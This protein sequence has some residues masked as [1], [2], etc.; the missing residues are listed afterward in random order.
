MPLTSLPPPSLATHRIG[1]YGLVMG[2]EWPVIGRGDELA[3]IIAAVRRG[4][5]CLVVGE[6]GVGKTIVLRELRRRL[7]AQGRSAHLVLVTAVAQFPLQRVGTARADEHAVLVI[8]DAHLLDAASA[9]QVW[10]LAATGTTVV[11]A[12]RAGAPVPDNIERLWRADRCTRL[13]LGPFDRADVQALLE[14]VLGDDVEDRVTRLLLRRTGGNALL[15]RELVRSAVEAGALVRRHGVWSLAGELPLGSGV[16]ELIRGGLAGLNEAELRVARLLAVGEPVPLAVAD[17]LIGRP[18]LEALEERRVVALQEAV[19][20]LVVTLGHPL[21]GE[22]LRADIPALQLRRLHL[23]LARVIE[24]V[25]PV[26]P[27]DVVRAALWRVEAG[28][29]GDAASLLTAAGLARAFSAPSAERL[30]EAAMEA[31]ATVDGAIL[32]ASLLAMIGRVSEAR[33]WLDRLPPDGLSVRQRG[34]VA[35]ARAFVQTQDGQLSEASA[36][37]TR[38]AAE[39]AESSAHLRAIH[40]QALTFDGRLDEGLALATSLFDDAASDGVARAVAAMSAVA[41]S[42]FRGDVATAH[43]VATQAREVTEGTRGRVPYALGTVA[44]A[45]VITHAYAGQLAEAD[46]LASAIY[47]RGLTEDDPWLRPRGASGLGVVALHRGQVRTAA[48]YF[49]ITVASLNEFDRLFLRYNLAFLVRGAALCGAVEEAER[50]LGVGADA[51]VFRLFE[52]DWGQARAAVLAAREQ[53]GEAVTT[54]LQAA[55]AAAGIGAWAVSAH[56]AHDAVRYGGE[57]IA[58]DLVARAARRAEGPIYGLLAEDA[59]ARTGEDARRLDAVGAGFE[60]LGVLLLAAEADYAAA[61]A[62]RAVG[63]GPAA[64]AS[65]A[66]AIALHARCEGARIPWIAP[67]GGVLTPREQQVAV[68]AAAGR[69]DAQIAAE[70]TISARTVSTHLTNVYSK[71]GVSTRRDL[72]QAL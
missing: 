37:L 55:E 42:H 71:L 43:R 72:L 8:D 5:G 13:E 30:A 47:D 9:A 64:A 19:D 28:E 33:R 51:P 27:R 44:V 22:V 2:V 20:G 3:A 67:Q 14:T 53:F 63:H 10:H 70:L 56:A 52:D 50:A 49:R 17:V 69:T 32:L 21:Y 40:A 38:L 60:D 1:N 24:S 36:M 61:G 46:Q 45:H 41:G 25:P 39:S 23:E 68:L 11:A 48:R 4:V 15:L 62:H 58:A 59:M 31:G 66:R 34:E 6:P 35:S 26:Q 7:A 29:P 16:R 12:V 18:V 57:E 65:L 54:A